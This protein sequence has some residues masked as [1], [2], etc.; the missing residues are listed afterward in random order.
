MGTF[1]VAAEIIAGN[2]VIIDWLNQADD[3]GRFQFFSSILQISINLDFK[4][5]L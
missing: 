4:N 3:T 5:A 2:T 1:V